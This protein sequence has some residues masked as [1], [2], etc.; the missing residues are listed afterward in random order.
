MNIFCMWKR[1][2]FWVARRRS[3]EFCASLPKRYVEVPQN[4]TL[5]C[6][7]IIADVLS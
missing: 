4:M 6:N 5:F 1:H 7:K 3:L 2:A